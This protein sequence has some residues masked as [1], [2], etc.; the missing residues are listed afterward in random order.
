M[1]TT[2]HCHSLCIAATVTASLVAATAADWPQWR[3][4]HRN[5]HG[6]ESGLMQQWPAEGPKPLW[7]VDDLGK[8]YSTPSVVGQRLYVMGSTGIESDYVTA[9]DTQNG[10][11]IWTTPVGKVGNPDQKPSFPSARSTPT[12]DGDVLYALGSDGD[13]ACLETASGKIRWKRQLRSDFGGKPGIWAYAESPLIDGDTLVCT[14]GGATATVL[15]LNK[16][17]GEVR[18]KAALPEADEAGYAS[19]ILVEAGGVR[20]YVQ[21]LQKGLVGLAPKS[22]ELLWRYDKLISKYGANIPTPVADDGIVFGGAAGT[23]A[24]AVQLVVD[25]G[26]VEAKPLY[27]ESKLPTA[28]GGAIKIGTEL[29]GTTAQALLC[30]DFKTGQVKWEERAIGAAS[31][32]FVDH[33]LYLHGENGIAALVEPSAEGYR[34]KGRFTPSDAPKHDQ[35]MEK[36]WAYPV[37]SHGKLYLRDGGTLWCFD[38]RKS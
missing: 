34:E 27:F 8:G 3:G 19:A 4:P 6:Q 32:C 7:R 18:W 30:V 5:G 10:K 26:R 33:R 24:G 11:V 16:S 37:V 15:A 22:G 31:L 29:Y 20:Q 28:I 13:L 17:T 2:N 9:R 36:S 25:G 12:V 38:V 35:P 14:P 21:L 1:P 23:G